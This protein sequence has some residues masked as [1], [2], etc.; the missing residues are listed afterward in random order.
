VEHVHGVGNG[1]EENVSLVIGGID[2]DSDLSE[3]TNVA[4]IRLNGLDSRLVVEPELVRSLSVGLVVIVGES[5][6]EG[7]VHGPFFGVCNLKTGRSFADHPAVRQNFSVDDSVVGGRSE[8][9]SGLVVG[10]RAS[11]KS[12]SLDHHFRTSSGRSS[13]RQNLR[14]GIGNVVELASLRN[15]SVL[16]RLAVRIFLIILSPRVVVKS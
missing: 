13:C 12:S 2:S 3:R 8:T 1:I 14:N 5:N 6:T 7:H 4:L 16:S 15:I 10:I 9:A 11:H